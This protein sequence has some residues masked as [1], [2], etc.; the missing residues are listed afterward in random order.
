M[1]ASHTPLFALA[2]C[3]ATIVTTSPAGA[4]DSD[5]ALLGDV[6]APAANIKGAA[7]TR[8]HGPIPTAKAAPATS[9]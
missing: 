9:S 4:L 7:C 5:R 2:L 6:P 8:A 1:P 3:A